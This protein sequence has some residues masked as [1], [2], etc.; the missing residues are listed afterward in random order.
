M[1]SFTS[2]YLTSHVQNHLMCPPWASNVI[3]FSFSHDI[4]PNVQSNKPSLLHCHHWFHTMMQKLLVEIWWLHA[5]M[6]VTL[7][8]LQDL[9]K[10][11]TSFNFYPFGN[12]LHFQVQ[13]LD[14]PSIIEQTPPH[15]SIK[16]MI[17]KVKKKWKQHLKSTKQGMRT[18]C[19]STLM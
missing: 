16:M 17:W 13:K 9:A 1:T 18:T 7:P 2:L 4:F 5:T 12:P 11:S 15:K 6:Q 8:S 3:L 19:M 10:W 14:C